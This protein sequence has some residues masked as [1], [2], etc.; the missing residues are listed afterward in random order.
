MKRRA[1]NIFIKIALVILIGI[2]YLLFGKLT[3][4]YIPCFFRK[5]TGFYCPGCGITHLCLSIFQGDFIGAFE[6]N[7]VIFIFLP[8]WIFIFIFYIVNF[9][10]TGKFKFSI[11]QNI[12]LWISV[13]SLFIFAFYRN[14]RL[15]FHI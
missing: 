12:I 8:I 3:G 11:F 4:F 9:I 15:F 5:I 1:L 13:F 2:L 7:P 14:F 10:K 6:S